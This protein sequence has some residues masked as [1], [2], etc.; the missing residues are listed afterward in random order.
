[1]IS[2]VMAEDEGLSTHD[3]V[4]GVICVKVDTTDEHRCIGGWGRDDDLLGT[5]LK[6]GTS[7]VGGGEHTLLLRLATDS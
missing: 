6:M 4:L 2:F 7:L 1:M 3:S 5:T